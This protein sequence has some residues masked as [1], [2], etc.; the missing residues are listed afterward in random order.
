M[1]TIDT[2]IAPTDAPQR[3]TTILKASCGRAALPQYGSYHRNLLVEELR[4]N[5]PATIW[6]LVNDLARR[7]DP[8]DRN[9][10][11]R[12]RLEYLY[13]LKALLKAGAIHR[14]GRK[15]VC[16]P[17]HVPV[18]SERV[19]TGEHGSDKHSEYRHLPG[20]LGRQYRTAGKPAT[21]FD[22]F[23]TFQTE[24]KQPISTSEPERH[25]SDKTQTASAPA[26]ALAT[27]TVTNPAT[28]GADVT[29]RADRES[30]SQA[31]RGLAA[32]R[33]KKKRWT[34]WL[35]GERCWRGRLVILPDGE[36]AP[37]LWCSRGRV[38]LLNDRDLDFADYLR[39]GRRRE[40]EVLLSK[41][42]EAALLGSLKRGVR[43]RPS[44][45]KAAA[46]RQNSRLPAKPGSRPR[47]RPRAW[48]SPTRNEDQP[49]LPT[50]PWHHRTPREL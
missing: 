5:G 6:E 8:D 1:T 32:K 22:L 44:L 28:T 38:L 4:E 39:W 35:H 11:R 3:P 30:I 13:E 7:Q 43:E 45:S 27:T 21:G 14:L 17:E 2:V 25:D 33:G 23:K 47:G 18:N 46:A 16:L 42:P 20:R 36:V 12:C 29:V 9:A 26:Y 24:R 50:C 41:C 34:G 15:C 37:L 19:E 40:E 49:T 10:E 31:A 48:R